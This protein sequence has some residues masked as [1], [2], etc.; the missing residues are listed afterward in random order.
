VNVDDCNV[1]VRG[2]RAAADL[3]RRVGA[4]DLE[5]GL[6]IVRARVEQ[7]R[8][9]RLMG[10]A[11]A[12]S[13][14]AAL[15][16]VTLLMTS[17]GD[18]GR[19]VQA[20]NPTCEIA[21]DPVLVRSGSSDGTLLVR[22]TGPSDLEVVFDGTVVAVADLDDSPTFRALVAIPVSGRSLVWGITST[23]AATATVSSTTGTFVTL[24]VTHLSGDQGTLFIGI[25]PGAPDLGT[26]ATQGVDVRQTC[27]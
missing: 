10:R 8:R 12:L 15:V 7:K 16:V 22:R 4:G 13:V 27:R 19:L 14:A 26:L 20:G 11:S 6:A 25:V 2:Q 21:S 1:D 23:R 5:R 9:V 17:G 3:H 24:E 18:D